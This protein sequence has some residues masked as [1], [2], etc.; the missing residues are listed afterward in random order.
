[1]QSER[2][3]SV[4]GSVISKDEDALSVY[5]DFSLMSNSR[6]SEIRGG[7]LLESEVR[8]VYIEDIVMQKIIYFISLFSEDVKEYLGRQRSKEGLL[9]NDSQETVIDYFDLELDNI[10]DE[11][12]KLILDVLEHFDMF[13]LCLII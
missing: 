2:S 6:V 12:I 3:Y 10:D 13:R 7:N 11:L 1:L 4:I 8:D 5:S 9:Q